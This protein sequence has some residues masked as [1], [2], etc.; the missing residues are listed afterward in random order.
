MLVLTLSEIHCCMLPLLPVLCPDKN[1]TPHKLLQSHPTLIPHCIHPSHQPPSC[2]PY[3]HLLHCLLTLLPHCN[4][5]PHQPPS[6]LPTHTCSTIIAMLAVDLRP[7]ERSDPSEETWCKVD[8]ER[9]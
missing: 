3:T 4:H 9:R 7:L 6:S 5:P 8:G 1:A 2:P